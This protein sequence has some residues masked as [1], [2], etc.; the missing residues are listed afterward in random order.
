M[1]IDINTCKLQTFESEAIKASS[2]TCSTRK[3][4]E[5]N[6]LSSNYS[7]SGNMGWNC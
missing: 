3:A 4:C 7:K 1:F 6:S 2:T 5:P